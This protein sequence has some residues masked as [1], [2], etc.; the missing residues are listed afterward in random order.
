[1][2]LGIIKITYYRTA[3]HFMDDR[4]VNLEE[5]IL[6]FLWKSGT[7]DSATVCLVIRLSI[8]YWLFNAEFCVSCVWE[9]DTRSH[10]HGLCA[11]TYELH[12]L[13][14]SHNFVPFLGLELDGK[15]KDIITF[16]TLVLKAE[17]RNYGRGVTFLIW[18]V[19]FGQSRGVQTTARR[20]SAGPRSFLWRP[21]ND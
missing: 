16:F 3:M 15:T 20:P 8:C 10:N 19:V 12:P 17:A 11:N 2:H 1:M 14:L 5:V 21:A 6:T 18:L 13:C 7:S 4:F 9:R